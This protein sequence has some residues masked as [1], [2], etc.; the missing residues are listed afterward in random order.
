MF[1]IRE[2][3]ATDIPQVVHVIREAFAEYQNQLDPPSSAHHK[4]PEIVQG[5]L[6]DGGGFVATAGD[7]IVGCAFYHNH[8][9]HMYLDRLAVLPQQRDQGIAHSLI[10][11]VEQHAMEHALGEVRLSVRLV[12]EQQRGLYEHL[13]YHFVS[14]GT[15]PGYPQPTFVTLGKELRACE[16][17]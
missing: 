7:S 13:G 5:E 15:H 1:T 4:T 16:K 17:I 12:L 9:R 2:M 8:A 10:R 6:A 11:A 14:Y 3:K